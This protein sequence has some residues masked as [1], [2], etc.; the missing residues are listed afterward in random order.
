MANFQTHLNVGIVMSAAT[1][2]GL[3]SFGLVQ[4]D[5]VLPYFV[6]GVSGSLLP[7]ID[8]ARSTPVTVLFNLL[9]IGLAFVM[10]LPL[11]HRFPLLELFLIWVG[12]YLCVRYGFFRIFSRLTVH[13][14]IWHSWLA[15]VAIMLLATNL[16]AWVWREPPQSAWIA[17]LITG[18]GY[19]THLGLDE[20]YSV[21]LFNRRMK[22]SFGT[23]L[24]LFSLRKPWSSLGMLMVVVLLA[25]LAP[26]PDV[27]LDWRRLETAIRLDDHL[28][29]LQDRLQSGLHQARRW[30]MR[31]ADLY[32]K[33]GLR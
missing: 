6:L 31:T 33:P 29:R 16:A 14:G 26:P 4:S 24:K 13:R 5:Q 7:D 19:L 11:I 20:I 27:G 15:T 25:W 32:S 28:D 2:L 21:D 17:G 8:S 9:G 22:R 10:T 18:L 23:A 12:V 1:T 3:Q 30:W